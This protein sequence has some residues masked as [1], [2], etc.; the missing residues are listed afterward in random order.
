MIGYP[1]VKPLAEHLRSDVFANCLTGNVVP[2]I[3]SLQPS[4]KYRFTCDGNG[5]YLAT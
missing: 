5:L 3:N 1:T 4:P 2:V